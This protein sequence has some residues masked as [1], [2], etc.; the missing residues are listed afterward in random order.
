MATTPAATT[1]GRAYR[2]VSLFSRKAARRQRFIDEAVVAFGERGYTNCSLADLCAATGLSKRQFYE[3]FHSKEDVLLA[4]YDSI[5]DDATDAVGAAIVFVE[6]VGI[7]E[8]VERHRRAR[9]QSW[10]TV[11]DSVVTAVGGP[12]ARAR[13]GITR[14]ATALIGAVNGI[15]H[16]W[17]LSSSR[18]PIESLVELLAPIATALITVES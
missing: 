5:Q 15:G 8:R 14:T 4:A 16:E 3:T 2:G 1:V 17:A 7:S 10:S 9:R 13:G 18:P 6:V 12:N 11:M